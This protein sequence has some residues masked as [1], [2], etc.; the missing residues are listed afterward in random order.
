MF[1]TR[2][3]KKIEENAVYCTSCG[4]KITQRGKTSQDTPS[5]EWLLLPKRF[6]KNRSFA[7]MAAIA[8]L[9]VIA[10]L[11]LLANKSSGEKNYREL[12]SNYY[13]AVHDANYG[14][15]L[16][17]YDRYERQDLKEDR[18]ETEERLQALNQSYEDLGNKNWW[19]TYRMISKD[20]TEADGDTVYY[21]VRIRLKTS[22][23]ELEDTL[24]IK[25]TDNRYYI[26]EFKDS[27]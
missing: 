2:C 13:K 11:L 6:I 18:A 8:L 25:K 27:F 15:L 23:G 19:R 9:T 3:G 5:K 17:C 10:S 12:V 16:Q 1:C 7:V 4:N 20:K 14:A 21:T 22:T 24:Y 26:N